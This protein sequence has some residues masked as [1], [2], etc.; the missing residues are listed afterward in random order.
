[1]LSILAQAVAGRDPQSLWDLLRHDVIPVAAAY[2]VFLALMVTYRVTVRREHRGSW[3]RRERAGIR[4]AGGDRPAWAGLIQFV[5]GTAAGGYVFF[6]CI[7]VVFYFALGGEDSGFIR[8]ALVEGSI[9]AF[10]F[11]VP[12]FLALSWVSD[13][14]SRRRTRW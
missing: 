2:L 14:R 8:Q 13:R 1:M 4:P 12:V 10:G 7:V 9:L 6:L 11:V 5:V 3:P